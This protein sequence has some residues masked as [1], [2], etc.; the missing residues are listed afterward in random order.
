MAQ[1]LHKVH[2]LRILVLN[3]SLKH[4]QLLQIQH[5]LLPFFKEKKKLR[6]CLK[7][8]EGKKERKNTFPEA[9]G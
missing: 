5:V 1:Q 4:H 8:N 7:E 3:V 6:N 2:N 9:L